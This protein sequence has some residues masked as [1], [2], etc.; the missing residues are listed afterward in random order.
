M[1]QLIGPDVDFQTARKRGRKTPQ[2]RTAVVCVAAMLLAGLWVVPA[3]AAPS[4]LYVLGSGS[5]TL[6][7]GQTSRF[8]VFLQES[9]SPSLLTSEG[10]LN[11]AGALASRSA[12]GLPANPSAITGFQLASAFVP[13]G[14]LASGQTQGTGGFDFA[15]SGSINNS[16]GNN[17]FSFSEA[18]SGSVGAGNTGNSVTA[19]ANEVYLGSV[20]VTAGTSLGTTTFLLGSRGN[21]NNWTTTGTNLYDLDVSNNAGNGGGATYTGVGANT[22]TF[23]V[24]VVPETTGLALLGLIAVPLIRRRGIRAR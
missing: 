15:A 11:S 13:T 4:Y 16:G 3:F 18:S 8:D 20:T 9:G 21:P 12:A 7:P 23:S 17:S 22:A 14:G 10:G 6:S 1:M 2:N 5:A 24:D 19:P